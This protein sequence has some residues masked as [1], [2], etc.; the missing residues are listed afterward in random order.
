VK[1]SPS[2]V[3]DGSIPMRNI[4][5]V[6][7]GK[8]GVGKSTVAANL[9]VSL[10]QQGARVALIDGDF[11]GPSIPTLFGGGEV[12][13]DH[14]GRLIPPIKFGVKY[15][16]IGFLMQNPDD[17]V[18]WRGPMLTKALTQLFTDVN[19]GEVD[20]ALIDMP[21]GTGDAHISLAQMSIITIQGAVVVTTPQEVALADVRKSMNMLRKV[22]I[23][24]IG[25]VENMAGLRLPNGEIEHIFGEGGG[26]RIATQFGVPLLAS[27]P[28]ISEIRVGGDAGQP[29]VVTNEKV[30]M[31]F[32]GVTKQIEAFLDSRM[33]QSAVSIIN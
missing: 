3:F 18:I 17:A 23:D 7:S 11:Y 28:L 10:A 30:Q 9:A 6:M 31:I 12:R 2:R 20:Y 5:A 24:V 26:K 15:M 4:I 8:G 25:V 14:E 13:A 29:S 22:N 32:E 16:S 21:P 27:I 33:Q 1:N 19:W